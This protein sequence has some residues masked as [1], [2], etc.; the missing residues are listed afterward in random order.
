MRM[1]GSGR[2]V[3]LR[4]PLGGGFRREQLQ[5]VLDNRR[6]ERARVV[7][8]RMQQ[9]E[10]LLENR[11]G[12]LQ[13]RRQQVDD[14]VEDVTVDDHSDRG[15]GDFD[16]VNRPVLSAGDSRATSRPRKT[17][18][19]KTTARKTTAARAARRGR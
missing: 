8:A 6:R 10:R 2:G 15:Q 3:G 5:E 9:A 14:F 13:E 4:V 11:L 17:T 16:F 1:R 12:L 7:S 19:R 18:A